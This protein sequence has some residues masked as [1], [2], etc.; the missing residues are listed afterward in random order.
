MY[1]RLPQMVL[2]K[3][4]HVPA[5][6]ASVIAPVDETLWLIHWGDLMQQFPLANESAEVHR[7]L[8]RPTTR[9]ST[10][11]SLREAGAQLER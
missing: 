11:L 8:S 2:C 1:K 7:C 6:N 9:P 5:Y 4:L 10:R 3:A